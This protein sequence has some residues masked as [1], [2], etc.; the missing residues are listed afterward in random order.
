MRTLSLAAASLAFAACAQAAEP[1]VGINL[2]TPGEATFNINGH[3]VANNNHPR[4]VKLYA[5][6]QFTP[7]WAGELGFGA[8][9]SWH[10]ADPT[11]GSTYQVSLSSQV[12]YAAVRASQPLGDSVSVFAKAGLALNRLNAQD[13]L[14][15]HDRESYVKPLFGAGLAWQLSPGVSAIVEYDRY[16]AR[17]T[18][19][20]R[21]TQQKLE[22]G[23][24][25]R[26]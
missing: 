22:A 14:G 21:F 23:L 26:F 6:L 24:A 18:G 9:G 2:T 3:S 11:P 13:S 20:G 19:I 4:A 12:A 16:G 25:V 8:F 10:A 7:T 1:Y 17:G 5:G 15:Q